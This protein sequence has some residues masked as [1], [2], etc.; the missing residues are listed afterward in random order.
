MQNTHWDV[1]NA[2]EQIS[3]IP[4]FLIMRLLYDAV[5]TAGVM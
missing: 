2:P 5:S 1:P 4:K 3:N